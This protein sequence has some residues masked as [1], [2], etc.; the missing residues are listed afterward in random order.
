MYSV[1]GIF[2]GRTLKLDEKV[3]VEGRS[4]VI[5]TFLNGIKKENRDR[6]AKRQLKTLKTGYEMGALLVS[7]RSSIYER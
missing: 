3:L 4:E 1:K 7:G 2:D 5:L 6:I